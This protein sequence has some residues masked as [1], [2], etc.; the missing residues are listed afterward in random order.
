MP[1]QRRAG[2]TLLEMIVVLAIAA[3][4]IGIG[5]GAVQRMAQENE[6]RKVSQ[7]VEALFMQAAQRASAT[8]ITQMVVFDQDG[9]ELTG[10][11]PQAGGAGMRVAFPAGTKF[12]LRRMGSDR[13]G[14]AAGQRLMILPGGLCE[15]LGLR[16]DWQN[17]TVR[18]SL[19]PLT[20]GFVDVEEVLQ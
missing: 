6:L 4:I 15:P 20:G 11:N 10:A 12:Q 2:F 17:S 18:A 14:A 3:L 9:V 7:D 19:D 5:A 8:S 1:M 13:W 16:L